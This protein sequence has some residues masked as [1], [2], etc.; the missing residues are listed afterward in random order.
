MYPPNL[1]CYAADRA[2]DLTHAKRRVP[3]PSDGS[4]A[5]SAPR[6]ITH[7]IFGPSSSVPANT[8]WQQVSRFSDT[9]WQQQLS[10]LSDRLLSWRCCQGFNLEP[11][12]MPQTE[13][14]SHKDG[15]SPPFQSGRLLEGGRASKA[16]SRHRQLHMGVPLKLN[17]F[18]PI[19]QTGGEGREK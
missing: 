14:E 8:D 5:R 7:E 19:S 6:F 9:A 1:S 18:T 16:E 10:R 12:S 11:S 15:E 2:W 4:A 17:R 13:L 3:Q